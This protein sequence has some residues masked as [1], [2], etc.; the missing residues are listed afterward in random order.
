MP[1]V[2]AAAR[3]EKRSGD[4]NVPKRVLFVCTGNTCRSP[5]AAA[6]LAHT[7]QQKGR[8]GS[9]VATSA[10]LFAA[11][12]AL[13]SQNAAIALADAGIPSA[14]FEGH[15]ARTVTDEI[16]ANADIVIGITGRHAMELMLRFPEHAAKIEALPIDIADPFG[17]DVEE[18]RA[19]LS[20]LSYAVAMRFFAGEGEHE[21]P[22]S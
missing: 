15:A 8:D 20:M 4:V 17:G 6:L 5:M 18:Y 13:I 2:A 1:N 21:D 14:L 10:G 7:A 12:G 9:L 19:C 16:M 22:K 3:Q 11:D